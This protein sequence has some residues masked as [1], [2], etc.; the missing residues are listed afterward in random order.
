[1]TD[2]DDELEAQ[3]QQLPPD[4]QALLRQGRK[5]QKE[6]ENE[7]VARAHLELTV[8]LKDAGVPEHPARELVFKDYDGPT[9]AESLKAHAA[10]FGIVEAPAPSGPSDAELEAQRRI[11]QAGAGSP[12]GS[13]DIDLADAFRNT[14]SREEVLTIIAEMAGNPGFKSRDGL[15]GELPTI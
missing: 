3:H 2:Q 8:A 12:P 6:L 4:V 14:K 1:M 7:R 13:G 9:D 11:I 10:K 5:A 15:I